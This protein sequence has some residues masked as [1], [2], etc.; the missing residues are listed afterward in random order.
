MVFF[1]I[2]YILFCYVD[3]KRRST[4]DK[5]HQ[6]FADYYRLYNLLTNVKGF[7]IKLLTILFKIKVQ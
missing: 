3:K 2:V 5:S 1:L 7:F 4:I 6:M